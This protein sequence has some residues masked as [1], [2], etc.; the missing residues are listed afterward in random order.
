MLGAIV[1]LLVLAAI[2]T[3]VWAGGHG[4]IN[5][6]VTPGALTAFIFYSV[7][8]AASVG[9]V[10]AAET[11]GAPVRSLVPAGTGTFQT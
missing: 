10:S 4:V 3:V 8:V 7:M 5:G 9:A 11:A 6:T 1:I 2:A